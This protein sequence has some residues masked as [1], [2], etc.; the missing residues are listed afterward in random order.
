MD[1]R[2]LP[3]L[4]LEFLVGP[5]ATADDLDATQILND[6]NVSVLTPEPGQQG[7][8]GGVELEPG[9]ARTTMA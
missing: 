2:Y 1:S 7:V 5:A 4:A 3:A 9:F 6:L 8:T